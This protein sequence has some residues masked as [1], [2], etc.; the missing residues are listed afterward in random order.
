[1]AGETP[2]KPGPPLWRVARIFFC[3]ITGEPCTFAPPQLVSSKGKAFLLSIFCTNG[4]PPRMQASRLTLKK[5]RVPSL[6]RHSRFLPAHRGSA[7]SSSPL[8]FHAPLFLSS[9][10]SLASCRTTIPGE[11]GPA[12]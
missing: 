3:L 2:G 12:C 8:A 7:S 5:D 11:D 9:T 10:P 1:M 6:A 4:H